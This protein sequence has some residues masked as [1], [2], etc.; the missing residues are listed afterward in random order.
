MTITIPAGTTGVFED[1]TNTDTI[2]AGDEYNL[3]SVTGA[4]GTLTIGALS[5]IFNATTNCVSKLISRG[6]SISAARYNKLHS[7]FRY[8]KQRS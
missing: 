6:M 2:A 4:G 3:R 5:V 1:T 7:Y 8:K